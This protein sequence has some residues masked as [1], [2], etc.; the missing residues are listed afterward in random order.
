MPVGKLPDPVL[1]TRPAALQHMLAAL[2]REPI[3][4]VDTESNSLH[5]YR[6]QVCLIQFSTE[7]VDYLVDPLALRDLSSLAALFQDPGIEK[8]FHAAEYD[9]L[10]LKRD[11][12][13]AFN[14]LFDTMLAARILGRE[15]FGLGALLEAEFGVSL[16]KRFQR[17]NWGQRPLP[18]QLLAYARLDTHYLIPLRDRLHAELM[19]QELWPL[20]A[21][22]FYRITTVNGNAAEDRSADC[23]RISGSFDLEPQQAAVLL[24]LCHY[25]DKVARSIN[26][27]LFKVLNDHTLLEIA[28]N[29][30]KS[31]DQLG[32]LPGMTRG[33][34]D[35]HG[36]ALL[37]AVQRGLHSEPAYPPRLP[38]PNEQFLERVE[39]LRRWRKAAA[40]AMG[41]KSDVILPR[42][43][44]FGI[45][46][47]NPRSPQ[48]LSALL[49]HV[50]WRL[51]RFGPQ[52]LAAI[53]K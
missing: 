44:L 28:L 25:R 27:P 37:A 48:E 36:Y 52:I 12:G 23:W 51:E 26:R 15:A 33:Q 47:H 35:R 39:A 8:V 4:A 50:P 31:L 34:V 10:C 40:E 32:R 38:R 13:F 46:E 3:V 30:P 41:V 5:A 6:E 7:Q 18:P 22:D 11:F 20:A 21:E 14:S 49:Q 9:L 24:E 42:D 19:A 2:Q 1:I 29:T 17:A 45:A 53:S 43:L 16:D